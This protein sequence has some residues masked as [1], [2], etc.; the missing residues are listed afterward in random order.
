MLILLGFL[1]ASS[2]SKPSSQA[3]LRDICSRQN[4]SQVAFGKCL[5]AYAAESA[6]RL[7]KAEKDA[8]ARIEN[9]DEDASY[10]AQ[11]RSTLATS[12]AEFLRF[13]ARE[14]SF[15][16]ALAGGSIGTAREHW[17]FACVYEL[18]IGRAASLDGF[19]ES[20]PQRGS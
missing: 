15:A 16:A 2:Q 12:N 7:A 19:V 5:E 1:L 17:Q 4:F 11:A 13:R 10:R 20:L 6:A 8:V 3:E 14:C 9:W 18:N